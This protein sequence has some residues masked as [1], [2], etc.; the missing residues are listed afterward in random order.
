[1][2]LT[3]FLNRGY[4]SHYVIGGVHKLMILLPGIHTCLISFIVVTT[5]SR[6]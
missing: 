5:S 4:I 3:V 6:D 1:M 2:K